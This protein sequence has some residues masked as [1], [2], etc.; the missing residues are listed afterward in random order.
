MSRE[1]V[2][3]RALNVISINEKVSADIWSHFIY[4]AC[5]SPALQL[6]SRI[7]LLV[8]SI[9]LGM[10]VIRKVERKA[11]ISVGLLRCDAV[12]TPR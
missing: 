8:K 3:S 6:D 7:Y 11:D 9:V 4:L 10:I 2:W 12:Y 5:V 1:L